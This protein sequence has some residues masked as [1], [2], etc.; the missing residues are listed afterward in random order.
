MSIDSRVRAAFAAVSRE[1]FLLEDQRGYVGE[2]RPLSIGFHQ[3]NSQPTTVRNMLE[4]LDVRAGDRVLDVGSGSGWT[5]ALLGHLTGTT[6]EVW[7]VEIVPELAQW[8]RSNVERYPLPWASVTAADTD[9]LGLPDQAPYD[10]ILASAEA[11][12][13]P[14]DLVEQLAEGGRMVIPVRGRLSV[15]DRRWSGQL[16]VRRVGHYAFVPLR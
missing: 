3:T 12:E 9:V 10:R 5:T 8:G 7:G 1:D 15:V 16:D 13:L 4:L 6:G 11:S 14:A 2:D